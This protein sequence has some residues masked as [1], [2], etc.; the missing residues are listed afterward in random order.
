MT[1]DTHS[2]I[3]MNLTDHETVSLQVAY[4]IL[5][6]LWQNLNRMGYGERNLISTYSG[7]LCT[8]EQLNQARGVLS[9]LIDLENYAGYLVTPTE[10]EEEGE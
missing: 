7:E 1:L 8:C 6:A 5:T 10:T 2:C 3:E 4:K 9:T